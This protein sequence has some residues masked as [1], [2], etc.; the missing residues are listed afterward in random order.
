VPAGDHFRTASKK[1]DNLEPESVQIEE[2]DA[3]LRQCHLPAVRR[4]DIQQNGLDALASGRPSAG[5]SMAC[6]IE[7]DRLFD[8][9]VI[10]EGFTDPEPDFGGVSGVVL[11]RRLSSG[12]LCRQQ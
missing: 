5:F 8:G 11:R 3:Y 2:G 1:L 4:I 7:C 9:A 12:F 10:A 6:K